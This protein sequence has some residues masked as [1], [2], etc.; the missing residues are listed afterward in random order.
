MAK[1]ER[2]IVLFITFAKPPFKATMWTNFFDKI[3]LVNLAKRVDR[4]LESAEILEKYQIPF[5][6]FTATEDGVGARGLRDTMNLL[7]DD[8][9]YNRYQNILVFEDD[10]RM[11]EEPPIFNLIMDKAVSQLPPNYHLFYLGGQPTG[12][13]SYRY[14]TNLLPALKYFAT[15]S[16]AYSEQGMKEIKGRGLGYP[17]D[18][19]LVDEIQVLGHCFAVDPL[20]CS[21]RKGFSDIGQNEIDWNPFIVAKH[22][23]KIAEMNSRT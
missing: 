16:V 6:I 12:G 2:V 15:Q 17:I 13:Y 11:V 1:K 9:L 21:Q 10:V 22:Q 23:Q 5:Q 19:W 7:F 3:Y 8:A 14:A 18:N 20:L 4:L